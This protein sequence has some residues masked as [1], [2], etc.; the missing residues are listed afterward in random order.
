M[1]DVTSFNKGSLYTTEG[2]PD[3]EFENLVTIFNASIAIPVAMATLGNGTN[4]V[5]GAST[6]S[7]A[8]SPAGKYSAPIA[9]VGMACRFPGN[10]SSPSQLWDLCAS[11]KDGWKP[12]PESR[13]DKNSLYHKDYTRVGRVS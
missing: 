7:K 2:Q 10:V 11:G 12:I 6:P 8:G 5:H 9:I 13:F 3:T 1:F 4:G